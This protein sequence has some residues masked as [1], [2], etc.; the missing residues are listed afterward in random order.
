MILFIIAC[1][2]LFGLC[3]GLPGDFVLLWE[4]AT[5]KKEAYD[6][7][8]VARYDEALGKG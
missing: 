5:E 4:R 2:G 3:Y 6:P 7:Y 1:F 8:L